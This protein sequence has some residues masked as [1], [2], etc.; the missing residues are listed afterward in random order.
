MSRE[1]QEFDYL[2]HG[3]AGVNRENTGNVMAAVQ[4]SLQMAG[5]GLDI[6]SK[7]NSVIGF[8]P[9]K[10]GRIETIGWQIRRIADADN[11]KGVDASRIVALYRPEKSSG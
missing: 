5:H 1:D 11:I 4:M 7:K 3:G 2:R 8:D 9:M 10:D 6:Q